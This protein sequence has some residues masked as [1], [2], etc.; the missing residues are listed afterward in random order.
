MA[1]VDTRLFAQRIIAR[2]FHNEIIPDGFDPIDAACDL[3][4]AIDGLL[5]INEAAQLSDALAG[6][7]ADLE[8]LEKVIGRELRFDLGGDDGIVDIIPRALL[9][10][11]RGTGRSANDQN[12]NQKTADDY[13]SRLHGG[14]SLLS[15]YGGRMGYKIFF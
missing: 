13:I 4:C 5:R 14:C 1:R 6:L 9:F 12:Q 3:A 10:G 8:R 11:C 15:A 2:L 7:N